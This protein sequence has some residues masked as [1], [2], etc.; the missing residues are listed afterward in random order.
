MREQS[1]NVVEYWIDKFKDLFKNYEERKGSNWFRK[2]WITPELE[3]TYQFENKEL[4]LKLAKDMYY[5]GYDG[6]LDN[7]RKDW[8]TLTLDQAAVWITKAAALVSKYNITEKR[9]E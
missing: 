3:K 5:F 8:N 4:I 2:K 7:R 6:T 9:K 1:E